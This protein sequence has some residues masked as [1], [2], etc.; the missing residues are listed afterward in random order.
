MTAKKP[1]EQKR[2]RARRAEPKAAWPDSGVARE[3]G[4]PD[5][6]RMA[7]TAVVEGLEGPATTAV[8]ERFPDPHELTLAAM[9]GADL[10]LVERDGGGRCSSRRRWPAAPAATS[11]AADDDD[12]DEDTGVSDEPTF[13]TDVVL[14][15]LSVFRTA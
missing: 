2:A 10:L 8:V 3:D 14:H 6:G 15:R 12:A 5:W 7:M 1:T 9:V 11:A 13:T 4:S